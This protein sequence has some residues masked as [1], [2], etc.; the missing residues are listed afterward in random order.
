[1]P[2]LREGWK[3]LLIG[4]F[5]FGMMTVLCG[6]PAAAGTATLTW[7]QPKT[8][9]DGTPLTDLAGYKIYY[10]S[11][12]GVYTNTIDVGNVRT[13][14]LQSLADGVT[15]YFNVTAYNTGL[16]ES[17]Y[18]TEVSKTIPPSQ[19]ALSVISAGTG[20]G[21]VTSAPAGISCGTTCSGSFTAGTSVILTATP[22]ASST[23]TGW[24][25]A[26]SG[27]GTCAVTMTAAR[28]A[29]ATFAVRTF[30]ISASAGAN[31]AIAPSGAV[32]VNYGAT[33]AFTITPGAGY[34]V[35]EVLVDGTSVGA[36]TSYSFT[37]VLA[38]HSISAT[39]A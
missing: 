13:Y 22:N 5:V 30:T 7:Q 2:T 10:G 39:F 4:T 20:S 31:G 19:Y 25:G 21:T 24:S 38:G 14:Q 29:T 16:L 32:S 26:C 3:K 6:R 11:S 28:S 15:Y 12:S 8:Y 18:A 33:R 35:A 37:N 9:E 17:G 27:T 36:V 23:F 34:H 1:M